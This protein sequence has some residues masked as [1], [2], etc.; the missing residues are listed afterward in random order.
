MFTNWPTSVEV[1]KSKSGLDY[2]DKPYTIED[3]GYYKV[4]NKFQYYIHYN[5]IEIPEKENK[6]VLNDVEF[7]VV[8][9]D[10]N[11]DDTP[12][13]SIYFNE[14]QNN[15]EGQNRLSKVDLLT[16]NP[17]KYKFSLNGTNFVIYGNEIYMDNIN[18]DEDETTPQFFNG[19]TTWKCEIVDDRFN[20][21]DTWYV[22]EKDTQGDYDYVRYADAKDNKLIQIYVTEE[23]YAE[24][25]P[26]NLKFQFTTTGDD[27]WRKVRVEQKH[28]SDVIDRLKDEWCEFDGTT[29]EPNNIVF[30][31][32]K[33]YDWHLANEILRLGNMYMS[34]GTALSNLG[35]GLLYDGGLKLVTNPTLGTECRLHIRNEIQ[36]EDV[37]T[38]CELVKKY[39]DVEQV[40]KMGT[41]FDRDRNL[42]DNR[43]FR[44][45]FKDNLVKTPSDEDYSSI[46]GGENAFFVKDMGNGLNNVN[47]AWVEYSTWDNSYRIESDDVGE[48]NLNGDTKEISISW[49]YSDYSDQNGTGVK[50]SPIYEVDDEG[51]NTEEIVKYLVTI[52][53]G[54]E[55]YTVWVNGDYVHFL[56]DGN[57][58]RL[59][60]KTMLV[61]RLVVNDIQVETVDFS[62]IYNPTQLKD[63]LAQNVKSTM[64]NQIVQ[65]VIDSKAPSP[66]EIL[67]EF[68]RPIGQY[69][70]MFTDEATLNNYVSAYGLDIESDECVKYS[71]IFKN[72]IED[73]DESNMSN[74]NV[75][76]HLSGNISSTFVDEGGNQKS[77]I[78]VVDS[79][80]IEVRR[81]E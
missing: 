68:N 5:P 81:I 33:T 43:V 8:R 29:E 67:I 69:L 21:D 32:H 15:T 74:G 80:S 12:I 66:S 1:D 65:K 39:G 13:N 7:Y 18:D 47:T 34:K 50:L 44:G 9:P 6:F 14:F 40:Q 31:E 2:T 20:F 35:N 16:P 76:G 49:G 11:T 53:D 64:L 52:G 22:I 36:N 73:I 30:T 17:L 59:N 58:Y 3:I 62:T 75:Y 56:V 27:K 51:N 55:K 60:L 48:A 4:S 19:E 79:P 26:W 77:N 38:I 25:N 71:Q 23:G 78:L 24:Y 57:R 63:N 46:P 54:S 28:Q 41:L 70:D 42:D 37:V 72:N 61:D 45:K 10:G